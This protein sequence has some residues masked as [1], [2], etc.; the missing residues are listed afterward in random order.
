[1]KTDLELLRTSISA[2]ISHCE[3]FDKTNRMLSELKNLKNTINLMI[4]G[5]PPKRL[6]FELNLHEGT[7]TLRRV[8]DLQ[9]QPLR[10]GI[11]VY[12]CR[13]SNQAPIILDYIV[14]GRLKGT[15]WKYLNL[16]DDK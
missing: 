15:A 4:N 1:M 6:T 3:Q 14:R 9:K 13:D 7:P 11:P 5:L 8:Y 16:L 10:E 2:M 12:F